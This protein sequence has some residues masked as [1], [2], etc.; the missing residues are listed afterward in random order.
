M[1]PCMLNR[2]GVTFLLGWLLLLAFGALAARTAP[3]TAVVLLEAEQFAD[4][5]GWVVDQ[6]FMD[7]M[8]SSYLLAHGLGE[9]VRGAET[10]VQFP[11]AANYRVWVRTLDWVAQQH[12]DELKQ[13][14]TQG[15]G[16]AAVKAVP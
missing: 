3:E 14:M 10:T 15:V 4:L 12:L 16:R 8:G 7:Q 2:S 11:A 9:P 6:Q 1:R 5:G 13:L